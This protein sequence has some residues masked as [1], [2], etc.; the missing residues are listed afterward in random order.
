[1]GA[2][3]DDEN[4]LGVLEFIHC[5][6]ETLDKVRRSLTHVPITIYFHFIVHVLC[7]HDAEG[8]LSNLLSKESHAI[9]YCT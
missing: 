9:L 5:L 4:E 2:D 6:V 1:M 8:G 7:F 3:S